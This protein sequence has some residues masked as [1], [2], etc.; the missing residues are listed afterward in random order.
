MNKLVKYKRLT[1]G[2][3]YSTVFC[4][5]S[6]NVKNKIRHIYCW[7]PT[8]AL[9]FILIGLKAKAESPLVT[10]DN[11][12]HPGTISEIKAHEQF[13]S[14]N[15]FVLPES[16]DR[17]HSS[18]NLYEPATA[19][20]LAWECD[21]NFRR[22]ISIDNSAGG[23]LS[24]YQIR[25]DVTYSANMSTDFSDLKFTTSSDVV[26]NHWIE[27][28]QDGVSAVV[29][30]KVPTIAASGTTTLYMYYGGC[31]P[32]TANPEDVFVFYDDF[33]NFSG[34]TIIGSGTVVQ[35]SSAFAFPVGQKANNN[36]PNG[37]WKSIGT[38]LDNFRLITREQRPTGTSGG[39]LNRYGV[40]N[41]GFNGYTIN[42]TGKNNGGNVTFGY[43]R[44]AG[45]VGGNAVQVKLAQPEGTW[46]RTELTRCSLTDITGAQLYSDSDRSPL[47]GPT[48]GSITNYNYNG[49]DRVTIRGGHFYYVDFMAVAQYTC[50]EPVVSIGAEEN[51][52]VSEFSVYSTSVATGGTVDFTDNSTGNPTSWSW[53]FPGGTPSSSNVQ[54]P[55]VT[56]A[57]AGTYDV[58]LQVG[59]SDG[60]SDTNVKSSYITV[61]DYCTPTYTTG[62]GEGD[63]ID[64]VKLGD[65]NNGTGASANPFYNYYSSLS[66]DLKINSSHT[67]TVRCGTYASQNNISVWIDYDGNGVFETS[68]KLG[69]VELAANATGTID[70]TVPSGAKLGTTRMRVRESWNTT[71]M[72]PCLEYTYGE[73]EDYNVNIVPDCNNAT[74]TLTTSNSTQELCLSESITDIEYTVGGDA[75]GAVVTGL[76][77]GVT[78]VYTA[79][80]YTISGTPT[81]TGVF[82]FTV[83]TT[84]TA[85]QGCSEATENG[86]ITVNSI[87]SPPTANDVITTYDGTEQS[88]GAVVSSNESVQWFTSA[89]NGSP[90]SAPT[91]TDVGT[92]TA[93]AETVNTITGCVSA[94]RTE[95]TLIINKKD[96]E[97]TATAP[98]ITYGDTEPVL[99]VQY[100]GFVGSDD[101]SDLD[102]TGFGLSTGYSQGDPVGTYSTAI[103]I[104]TAIDNNYNF[105]PLNSSTFDV[106]QAVINITANN[107]TVSYATHDGEI[108]NNGTYSLSGFV[109]GDNSSV[110]I[111][112]GSISYTTNYT[113]TSTVGASG[114]IITPSTSGLSATNYVL[115]AVSG[116]ITIVKADQYI[117]CGCVPFSRPLNEFDTIPIDATSSSGLPVSITLG[118]GSVAKLNGSPGNYF[119]TDIGETGTVTLYANQAGD[120]N[121]NP[122]AEGTRIFDVTKSNQNISFPAIDDVAY[123]NG[124]TKTLDAVASSGLSVNYVVLSGPATVSGNILTIT[125]AGTIS[126]R[127]DQPGNA[128]YNAAASVLQTFTVSK[129]TQTITIN[130]P[131]GT[132]DNTTPITATSTSGLP[133]TL[134]LGVGSDATALTGIPGGTYT[135]SGVGTV[136][137]GFVDI[138]GNQAGDANFLPAAQVIQNI[139]LSKTNQTITFN[140]ITDQTYSPTLTVSL[141]ATASSSLA[142][143]YTLISGPATLA[144]N[145]LT[146]TGVGTVIIEANQA[147]DATYNPAPVVTQQFEVIKATPVINQADIVKT[148]GDSPFTITPTSVSTGSFSFISGDDDIYTMSGNTVTIVGAGVTILDITQ[149]PS[150]NYFG[151]TKTVSFTVNKATSAIAVTGATAYTYNGIH[152]GPETSTVNGS[153]GTVIYSYQGTG[154]TSYGPSSAKPINAGSYSVTATVAED[155]NYLEATSAPY[156]FTISKANATIAL[157]AYTVTYDGNLHVTTGTAKGVSAEDLMGLDLSATAHT[158]ADNY[159]DSWSFTDMTGNYNDDSGT[160]NNIINKAGL[161]I[162]AN[163]QSK[164]FSE[165]ITFTGTEFNSTG[166]AGSETVGTATFTS[167]GAAPEAVAGTY[168]ITPSAATGGTFNPANYTI[169][170]VDGTL[171]VSPLPTLAGVSQDSPICEGNTA[172]INLSGL[173]ADSNFTINYSINGIAQTPIAGLV[174]DGSGNASFTSSALTLTNNGQILRI[175]EIEDASSAC[176]QTFTED[177]VLNVNP[178]P[179]LLTA[180]L[181]SSA[182]EGSGANINLSGLVPGTT[183]TLSYTING[184]ATQ[185]ETGLI[186]DG[187]GN[188]SFTTPALSLANNGQTLQI[189]QIEDESSSCVQT[190]AEDVFLIV[191]PTSVGGTAA[192]SET[193]LCENENTSITLSAYTG[194]IQ[195][196]QS[197][198]GASGW[199]NVSGGVGGNTDTYSTPSLTSTTY[200]RAVVTS[201]SC[202]PA[203]S[204]TALV[205]VNPLPTITGASQE[206]TVCEGSG[207]IINLSGL[208]PNTTFTLDYTI[209][210]GSTI[211]VTGL[212]SDASGNS[213]FTTGSLT[214]ANNGQTLQ[215]EQ[216]KNEDTNCTGRFTEDVILDVDPGSVGGTASANQTICSGN[217][218]SDITVT[219]SAGSIQWQSSPDNSNWTNISGATSSTLTS[220]EMGT[221][222]STTYYRAEVT[223]GVCATTHSNVVTVTVEPTPIAGTLTKTPNQSAIC[224][225]DNVS[226]S[227]IAGSGGNGT[228]ELEVSTNGGSNWSAYTSGTNISTAGLAEVQIRTRRLAST[229]SNSNYNMVSWTVTPNNTINLTSAV[230][231]DN[232]TVDV[233]TSISNIIYATTGATGATFTGLPNGVNGVWA[234]NGITISGAPTHIGTFSYTVELTGG[235]GTITATGQITVS[236]TFD[237]WVEQ[238]SPTCNAADGTSKSSGTDTTTVID[239]TINMA[240]ANTGWS[241]DWEISFTLLPANN[242]NPGDTPSINTV[243]SVGN[244][245]DLTVLGNNYT[246]TNLPSTNG[247]GTVNIRMNVVGNRYDKIEVNFALTEA[248]TITP[249]NNINDKDSDDWTATQIINAI[250]NT[251]PITTN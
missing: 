196:Q 167:A 92:Y 210:G 175:F 37:A 155:D 108:T 81:Q 201:G 131:A 120:S 234:A 174:A 199:V 227:L 129:G 52:L 184:G 35:N 16:A 113:E 116:S 28:K 33:S 86:A 75:T 43:E 178:L 233:Q 55:T 170:Y 123:Y 9:F 230:G 205:T 208:Q 172:T 209:N 151:A 46:F 6:I 157:N 239:F 203:Y 152:Q 67:V 122:A 150:A 29:W 241:P 250:P 97:V 187:L 171:L 40:E 58:T 154:S 228:D 204:T 96:L 18:P 242:T 30:V 101:A 214:V 240:T 148:V 146:I 235:C 51:G 221:L 126:V 247:D 66:T 177:V 110:I 17:L 87:P 104:G 182:C 60:C 63:F 102:N 34:W 207:A 188:S 121:Y 8:L 180:T 226:A 158:D 88:A 76:P 166:L 95:V 42:R 98:D 251:G 10:S 48:S 21:C 3:G 149:Q 132:I 19:T 111:G 190:F 26:L 237:V 229:C 82:N 5:R 173:I 109:N 244:V 49:F 59:N 103:A 206:A 134:T 236:N 145:V 73:T 186:A 39:S 156:N 56:Y 220:A 93:W 165:T 144:G 118:A 53:T 38:T 246:L 57:A 141:T 163:D 44:R 115:N 91:A 64:T 27:V 225:G 77:A 161:T 138:V 72:D 15:V 31:T 14:E 105:A 202:T 189:I 70:F 127:A 223:S 124:L 176:I 212:S 179:T 198:D 45:G 85:A 22:E 125:G 11:V 83:T 249:G 4:W 160:V 41:S 215:V 78:G 159:T 106:G 100:S 130:V 89:T 24:D 231:S 13:S 68:E 69:N 32:G 245:G 47:G 143:S 20:S 90:T 181:A 112:L 140:P 193:L 213:S 195:W 135:L 218:P 133:V 238:P 128:A 99:T 117:V 248:K 12:A 139:I 224:I 114:I 84:G 50:N 7:L 194:A 74:L 23:L 168:T 147:G 219:G 164:C 222:S 142:V 54:N 217:A 137:S 185:L 169:S 191:D 62:T 216:L 211:V 197:A 80:T 79:G 2:V 107:Q 119:L 65:I 200:Y 71:A 94:T 1:P 36:D 183:F 153:S 61:Q 243:E 162:T 232:Q 25:I 136:G 192:A